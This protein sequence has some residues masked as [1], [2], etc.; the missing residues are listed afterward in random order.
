[1]ADTRRKDVS[2]NISCSA[3]GSLSFEGAQLAVLMDIRDELKKLNGVIGCHN[4]I[5]VPQILRGIRKN[6][7]K[8]RRKRKPVQP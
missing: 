4:F 1:M 7:A 3:D 5:A 2:W 6:T 8:P